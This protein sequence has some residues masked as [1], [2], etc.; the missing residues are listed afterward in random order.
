M[1]TRIYKDAKTSILF[2]ASTIKNLTAKRSQILT[3][4]AIAD[5]IDLYYTMTSAHDTIF[6]NNAH[7]DFI[8]ICIINCSNSYYTIAI[9][10]QSIEVPLTKLPYPNAPL[11]DPLPEPLPEPLPSHPQ[12]PHPQKR[13]AQNIGKP[14]IRAPVK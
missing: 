6:G 3:C 14:K 5:F 7:I 13:Q 2:I 1:E 11:P 9:S 12:A 4:L 10:V 8:R